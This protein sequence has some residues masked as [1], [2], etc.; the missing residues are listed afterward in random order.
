MGCSRPPRPGYLR[1][2]MIDEE[3]A[4]GSYTL[5]ELARMPRLALAG[6]A[7]RAEETSAA[8]WAEHRDGLGRVPPDV[9]ERAMSLSRLSGLFA[10][11]ASEA[12]GR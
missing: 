4:L 8:M 6:L 1:A 7:M 11:L 3:R 2:A 5:D 12:E 9:E 10:E